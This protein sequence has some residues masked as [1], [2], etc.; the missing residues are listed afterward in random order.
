MDISIQ[1]IFRLKA[2]NGL[3]SLL[4][5]ITSFTFYQSPQCLKSRETEKAG[6]EMSVLANH[7]DFINT[8]KTHD[9]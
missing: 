1:R 5:C 9:A 8:D 7:S 4:N 2:S 6:S 3:F